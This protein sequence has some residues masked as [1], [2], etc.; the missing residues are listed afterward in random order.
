MNTLVFDRD[1]SR[2]FIWNK[3]IKS[4]VAFRSYVKTIHNNYDLANRFTK[5]EICSPLTGNVMTFK[6]VEY[7]PGFGTRYETEGEDGTKISL[8]IGFFQSDFES[9][10]NEGNP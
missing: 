5:I 6:F 10:D 8:W 3:N 9:L 4:L 2:I 7:R 1:Q